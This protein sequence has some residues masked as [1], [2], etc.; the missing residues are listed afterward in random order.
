MITDE[1]GGKIPDG[2]PSV[3]TWLA[4]DPTKP[5][6]WDFKVGPLPMYDEDGKRYIDESTGSCLY[7]WVFS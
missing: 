7:T 2:V 1:N 6:E 3:V 4:D 5:N